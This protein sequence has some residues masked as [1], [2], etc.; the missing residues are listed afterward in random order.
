MLRHIPELPSEERYPVNDWKIEQRRFDHRYLAQEESIFTVSNGF[1]G[2][3]GSFEEG[4]PVSH[5]ETFVNGFYETWPIV[6]GETAYGFA[7]TGQTMLNVT[8]AKIIQLYVDEEPFVIDRVQMLSFN[9]ALNMKDGTLDREVIWE[10]ASGKRVKVES[11]RLVSFKH[12][13]LA[14]IDYRV[15]LLDEPASVIISSEI[16]TE[17]GGVAGEA[18][19][20]ADPRK[21][22]KFQGQVF[23]PIQNYSADRRVMLAY[24]TRSSQLYIACGID[25][26]IEGASDIRESIEDT[27]T[28]GRFAF[29]A[30]AQPG[31]TIRLTKFMAYHVGPEYD[32]GEIDLRVNW[33]L[34]L[35]REQSFDH[36]LAEQIQY[37]DDFWNRSD[38][39]VEG[40]HDRMQQCL[41]FNV[42]QLLQATGRADDRGIPAKGLTGQAY[43]GHYF[44]DGEIYVLPFLIFTAPKARPPPARTPLP[45]ARK[46]PLP[47]P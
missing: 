32:G 1:L 28:T 21:A 4:R 43:E 2:L 18:Q 7:R 20:E 11:R 22:K 12:R 17:L 33:S 35:A 3:R 27:P 15:T 26:L 40:G 23:D 5:D 9:R 34:D 10:T 14:A 25:H 8:N 44:W 39:I 45:Y 46:S 41:R 24:R 6:Y 16:F 19:Q 37:M 13:H 38:L 31:H 29:R 47:R 42:F 36:L 30:E